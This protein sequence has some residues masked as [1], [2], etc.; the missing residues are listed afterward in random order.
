MNIVNISRQRYTTK[1]YDKT[2][3]I[4]AEQLAQLFEVIRNS[5]SS[6]NLQ[7]WHFF[8]VDNDAARARIMPAIMEL[9]HPRVAD[10][11]HTLIFCTKTPLDE[12]HL[13]TVLAQEEKDGRFGEGEIKEMMDKGRH[14]FVN[15]NSTTSQAQLE[16]E[17]KQLYIV[18]GQLLFAAAAIGIDSTAI[19]GFDDEK[20][21]DIL[22]LKQQ[23]LKSIL[24]V[25]LG[26][27]AAN[28]SNA[29]RPKSR[30]PKE[31]I[32]TRI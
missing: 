30:L 23:G 15:K 24:V 19:E 1:Y 6:V 7:P 11:S 4:A 28:D 31:Q 16:W 18:L 27:R 2:R 8:V 32:F 12:Q 10:S 26:Y 22:E 21:D 13:Q 9:N 14:F 29:S 3:K 17:S 5:P 25:S 20:M